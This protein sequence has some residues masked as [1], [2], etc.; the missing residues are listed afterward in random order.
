MATTISKRGLSVRQ[1]CRN[2]AQLWQPAIAKWFA[3]ERHFLVSR[4]VA[5][6]LQ[7]AVVAVTQQ[8]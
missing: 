3:L 1:F 7:S 5:L 8:V 6:R 2:I 4:S